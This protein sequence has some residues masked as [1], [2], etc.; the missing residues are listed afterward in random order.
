MTLWEGI[1]AD[2]D[3]RLDSLFRRYRAACPDVE[4]SAN[5]IP[6]LW[7]KIEARHSFWFL[8]G[9]LGR[10][11]VTASAALC[12][13]LLI[14]NLAS[15]PPLTGSYADAL[16]TDGSAEQT[17]FTEAIRSA[18]SGDPIPQR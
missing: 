10:N 17:Y 9:K 12:L 5:F 4:P 15:T 7:Q 6:A 2:D 18:P 1:A 11:A 16:M 13:L 8:F 3:A 14:L